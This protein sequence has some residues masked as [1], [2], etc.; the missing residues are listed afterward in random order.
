MV[1]RDVQLI[2]GALSSESVIIQGNGSQVLPDLSCES[3]EEADTRI[4]AH[5]AYR[6]QHYGYSHAVI[7]ATDTDILV[8]AIYHSVRIVVWK[9]SGCRKGRHT[10]LVTRLRDSWLK[11]TICRCL[12]L[13]Q[14]F[15]VV[16]S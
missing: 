2:L 9:N 11:R 16:T 6:V 3:H 12:Q 13:H 4:F 7:Q 8:M 5:L 10:Y 15:C 1:P 14:L